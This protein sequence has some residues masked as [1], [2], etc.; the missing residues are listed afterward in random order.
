MKKTS[1]FL[2]FFLFYFVFQ[3]IKYAFSHKETTNR[4]RGRT[5]LIRLLME[6]HEIEKKSVCLHATPFILLK[7]AGLHCGIS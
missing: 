6:L 4:L 2:L 1:N 3:H 5:K 7:T